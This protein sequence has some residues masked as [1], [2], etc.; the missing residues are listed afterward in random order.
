LTKK[1]VP[2][3]KELF[4]QAAEIAEQVP[5]NMQEAAFN[6]ALDLL[7]GSSQDP[8]PAAGQAEQGKKRK[9]KVSTTEAPVPETASRPLLESI[10]STQHPGVVSASK[11]LDRALMVLQIAIR[12]HNVDG[13]AAKDIAAVLTDKFR[14]ST[15][16]AAVRMALDRSTTLVNRVR[17]GR[18]VVYRIMGPGEDYLAHLTEEKDDEV[19]TL[20]KR[21]RKKRTRCPAVASVEKPPGHSSSGSKKKTSSKKA[22]KP[23]ART[24]VLAPKAAVM[25]LID[26]GYF[27]KGRTGGE[28]QKYLKTKKGFTVGADQLRLALLRLVRDGNLERDENEDGKYEYKKP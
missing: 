24:A 22:A 9:G 28:L 23:S 14:I 25:Q 18:G 26:I 15:T 27:S 13:L 1:T 21:S 17:R 19:P 20:K 12:D 7:T 10:D 5:E 2:D 4:K 8:A 16:A 6:R 3:L 11:A